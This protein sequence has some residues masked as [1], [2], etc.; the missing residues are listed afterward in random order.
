MARR[1]GVT[2][3]LPPPHL[4]P[5]FLD[6]LLRCLSRQD[7]LAILQTKTSQYEQRNLRKSIFQS[8]VFRPNAVKNK[9]LDPLPRQ[10]LHTR[11]QW[12]GLSSQWQHQRQH[13]R[14]RPR[15]HGL[16]NKAHHRGVRRMLTRLCVHRMHQTMH[17]K[18]RRK[19]HGWSNTVGRGVVKQ[20]MLRHLINHLLPQS[21]TRCRT[22]T[23]L[24]R[25]GLQS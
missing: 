15:Q 12:P 20:N 7:H 3:L 18:R 11:C 8:L 19:L 6:L 25:R 17:Q 22:M 9:Q 4:R 13:Q 2:T 21:H 10:T 1:H 24:R 5:H 16:Q 14:K 23:R